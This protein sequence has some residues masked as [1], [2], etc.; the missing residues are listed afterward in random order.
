MIGND[1]GLTLGRH[2][3]VGDCLFLFDPIVTIRNFSSVASQVIFFGGC[4]HPSVMNKMAVSNFPFGR[5]WGEYTQTG[6]RGPI[7]IGSDVWIGE[8]V[9]VMDGVTIGDGAIIG[10]G[11]VVGGNVPDYAV[12][13]GNPGR[14]K[15]MRF[16]Y[17]IVDKLRKIAWWNWEDEVIRMAMADMNNIDVFVDKY[18]I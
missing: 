8:R 18:Y 2:S 10:A 17:D 15:R 12:V 9:T 11:A 13:V 5:D 1:K 16:S 14:V 6:S 3:Y 7:T 4:E